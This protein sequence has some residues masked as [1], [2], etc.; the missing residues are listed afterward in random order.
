ML[1]SVHG[2]S[3][4]VEATR[5]CPLNARTRLHGPPAARHCRLLSP[6]IG[7]LDGDARHE[8]IGFDTEEAYD[9]LDHFTDAVWDICSHLGRG[10]WFTADPPETFDP[11][12]DRVLTLPI[13]I[14]FA[15][16][17]NSATDVAIQWPRL[18]SNIT[19]RG[20][21]HYCDYQRDGNRKI[22]S[23]RLTTTGSPMLSTAAAIEEDSTR[24]HGCRRTSRL[25]RAKRFD[26]QT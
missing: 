5:S 21:N 23:R 20:L 24:C 11:P 19:L 18:P 12:L 14:Q 15:T 26:S 17:I 6:D 1:E 16:E 9:H 7:P 3:P 22:W 2:L 10:R 13:N 4:D 8:E 25:V